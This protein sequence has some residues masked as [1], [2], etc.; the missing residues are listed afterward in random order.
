VKGR[1]FEDT[2]KIPVEMQE[3][4]VNI[5]KQEF[6]RCFQQ[7]ESSWASCINSEVDKTEI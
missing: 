3:R 1:I 6:Q 5:K 7:W 2:A 4:L